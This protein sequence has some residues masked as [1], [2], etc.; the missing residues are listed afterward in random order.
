M[1]SHSITKDTYSFVPLL[2]M[3]SKWS[4][5]ILYKRYGLTKAE[6]AFIDS[7]IKPMDNTNE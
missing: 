5:E 1:Y 2:D 4:D 6:I 3:S 7:K